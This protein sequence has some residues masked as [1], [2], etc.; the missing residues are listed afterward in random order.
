MSFHGHGCEQMKTKPYEQM[1][2]KVD[3]IDEL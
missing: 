2:F 3:R 1:N